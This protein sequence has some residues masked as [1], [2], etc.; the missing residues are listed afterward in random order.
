MKS[1]LLVVELHTDFTEITRVELIHE[2]A[3]MVLTTS[4]TTSTG[5]GSVLT[6]TTVTGTDVSSLLPVVV[7][8]GRHLDI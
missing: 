3:V 1:G 5:V 8:S 7:K 4:V 6:N 2:D